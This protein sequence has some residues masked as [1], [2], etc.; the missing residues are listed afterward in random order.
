MLKFLTFKDALRIQ[1]MCRALSF[2]IFLL[3]NASH[4]TDPNEAVNSSK[5]LLTY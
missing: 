2:V 1:K 3:L 4:D 5:N